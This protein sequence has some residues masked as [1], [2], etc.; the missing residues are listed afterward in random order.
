MDKT[1]IIYGIGATILITMLIVAP[2]VIG[3]P[4]ISLQKQNIV[5]SAQPATIGDIYVGDMY[6]EGTGHFHSS[7]VMAT[8]VQNPKIK[9]DL[10]GSDLTFRADYLLQ[11]TGDWDYGLVMLSVGGKPTVS[12]FTEDGCDEGSLYI[13]IHDCEA[14]DFIMWI[15]YVEYGDLFFPRALKDFKGGGTIC[16]LQIFNS[17]QRQIPDMQ[18]IISGTIVCQ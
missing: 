15:L 13:T 6:I 7:L 5:T 18:T 17:V 2:V 16:G 12:Y 1:K 4:I 11:C 8:A 14:G 9:V 3:R 10:G